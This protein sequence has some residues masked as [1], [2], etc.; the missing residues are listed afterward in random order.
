MTVEMPESVVESQAIPPRRFVGLPAPVLALVAALTWWLVGFLPWIL[1]G[2]RLTAKEYGS[3][4]MLLPLRSGLLAP[5]VVGAG[6]G[7]LIS[8]LVVLCGR[9]SRRVDILAV[10]G[11]VAGALVITL[12]Q[13]NQAAGSRGPWMGVQ[14]VGIDP[15]VLN[16]LTAVVVVVT[17][18]GLVLGLLASTG[19]IG[20]GIALAALAGAVTVWVMP[21]LVALGL[22]Q[23]EPHTTLT[24]VIRWA[25]AAVL[26]AA[27]IVLPVRPRACVIWWP[28]AVLTAWIV[29]PTITAAGYLDQV[30]RPGAAELGELSEHLSAAFDVWKAAATIDQR[31]LVP[32]IV[33]VVV[34]VVVVVLRQTSWTRRRQ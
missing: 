26:C 34:A 2:L 10:A 4:I 31:P 16:A 19:R 30:I 9:G 17:L 13:A 28:V 32:W 1:D 33:A 18:V 5:L 25:G 12:V 20:L 14:S 11:G 23:F 22:N 29:S 6:V 15:K 27:L 21:V 3:P 24:E 8:G 7:G